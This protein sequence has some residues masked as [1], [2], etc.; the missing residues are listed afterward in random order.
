MNSFKIEKVFDHY[1]KIVNI[2]FG[3][4]LPVDLYKKIITRNQTA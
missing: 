3:E 1:F 2:W 4:Y